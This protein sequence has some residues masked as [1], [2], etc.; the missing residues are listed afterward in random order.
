MN[1]LKRLFISFC[2]ILTLFTFPVS[3]FAAERSVSS[4][5]DYKYGTSVT[6]N[7]LTDEISY[8]D[9]QVKESSSTPNTSKQKGVVINNTQT[10]LTSSPDLTYAP[11]S[12]TLLS[13]Y[14]NV[15]YVSGILPDGTSIRGSGVLVYTN[16]LLTSGHMVY[17]SN[18]GGWIH[19]LQVMPA[20]NGGSAPLGITTSTSITTNNAWIG[21]ADPDW[22]WAIIDLANSYSTW[23][24]FGYYTDYKASVGS[25]IEHIGFPLNNTNYYMYHCSGYI[26]EAT[27]RRMYFDAYSQDGFSGGAIIDSNSGALVGITRGVWAKN[28]PWEKY[29]CVRIN[30]DLSNRISMHIKEKQ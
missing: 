29:D 26:T 24:T 16:I 28:Y 17:Q 23:Q 3:A 14:R 12:D 6:Y 9:D 11:I 22:D 8:G 7:V 18:H 13:P 30:E 20:R 10:S 27:D 21:N 25:L 5:S 2:C 1:N 19:D 4:P 15:C